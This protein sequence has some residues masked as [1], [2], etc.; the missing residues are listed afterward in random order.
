MD[1]TTVIAALIL[2]IVVGP[3]ARLL[4]PG[5]QDINMVMTVLLGAVGALAGSIIVSAVSSAEG[6]NIWA[7]LTGVVVAAVLVVGYVAVTGEKRG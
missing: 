3:L 7:L 5:K 4:L 1:T 6:F 2:G